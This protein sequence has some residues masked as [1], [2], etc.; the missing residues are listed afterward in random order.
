M[1]KYRIKL[2]EDEV[3]ELTSIIRKGSHSA[4][5]YRAALVLLNCDEGDYSEREKSTH[6]EISNFLRIGMRTIE[7]IKQRFVE[8]GLERALE[9]AESSRIYEKK[10]DGDLEARIVQLSCSEPPEGYAGWSLRLL[11]EKVV[12]LEYTDYL[13]HVSVHNTL[14]KTKLS[15]GKSKVG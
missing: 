13:S 2:T 14:K 10:V 12:D 15:H 11:A 3:S 8:G 9:R 6:E 4:H 1:V 7:R 5:S